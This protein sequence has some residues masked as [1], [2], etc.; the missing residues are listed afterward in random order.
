MT[1]WLSE[2]DWLCVNRPP[3]I[4]LGNKWD[5][6]DQR[7]VKYKEGQEFADSFGAYF[8]ETTIKDCPTIDAAFQ[9]LIKTI[10]IKRVEGSFHM[11]TKAGKGTFNWFNSLIIDSQ[12][13]KI[14]KLF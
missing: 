5:L 10:Y 13:G 4:V 11:K 2:V 6:T 14:H 12:N 8:A 9:I 3:I 1:Y 7:Q